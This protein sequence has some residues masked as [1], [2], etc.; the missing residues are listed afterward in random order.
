MLR[1]DRI[2]FVFQSF[3]LVPTLTAYENIT[4]PAALAGRTPDRDWLDSVIATVGLADRLRHRPSELSGGQQQRVAV[5]RALASRP[6]IVFADE[7]TGNLD[8]RSGREVLSFL[9]GAADDLGQTVVMV[10]HDPVAA[11]YAD[12][13]V[14]LVDG[15]IALSARPSVLDR[16]SMFKLTVQNLRARKRRFVGTFVAIVLGVAFL[17]G[18]LVLG[19]TLTANFDRLFADANAGTDVVVRSSIDIPA[20]DLQSG[21]GLIPASVVAQ[22]AAVDGVAAAEPQVSGYGQLIGRDGK[23]IGGNGP[24]TL[25]GNWI[26]NPELNAY[27]LAEGRAP[28]AGDEVVI[29]RGAAETGGFGIGD[30]VTV[31]TPD[32][33]QATVVGLSTFGGEDGFGAVT[34]TAF[35]FEA[36]QRYLAPGSA[37]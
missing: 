3:N 31:R 21:R 13:V 8:T 29:N 24:P 26:A 7:P 11:E 32:P 9:R 4:L 28:A 25:A 2:G 5:A 18:T 23:A 20:D 10:T 27:R 22:V 15:R 16:M 36:A 35:T 37:R 33:V 30:T 19:D 17:S 14:F 12:G 1:R 34:F 6:D